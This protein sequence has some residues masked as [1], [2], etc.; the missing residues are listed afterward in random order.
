MS[1]HTGGLRTLALLLAGS[2]LAIF[3]GLSSA[4]AIPP[5]PVLGPNCPHPTWSRGRTGPTS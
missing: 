3:A 5:D 1:A 4:G 2:A